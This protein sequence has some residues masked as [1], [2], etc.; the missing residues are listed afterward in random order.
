MNE[1]KLT[2][3]IPASSAGRV[4]FS[5]VRR[6]YEGSNCFNKGLYQAFS[7]QDPVGEYCT[8]VVVAPAQYQTH[9]ITLYD[10]ATETAL[11]Q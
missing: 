8:A 1:L 4:E 10:K 7:V 3:I 9:G 11:L 6:L 2:G 5:C